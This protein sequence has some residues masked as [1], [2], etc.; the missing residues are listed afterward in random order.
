[1]DGC[2]CKINNVQKIAVIFKYCIYILEI[3]SKK[4]YCM[5]TLVKNFHSFGDVRITGGGQPI[6]TYTQLSLRLD[7]EGS[8]VRHTIVTRDIRL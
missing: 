4:D 1:M 8:L 2:E 7:S 5:A 3:L 6:L